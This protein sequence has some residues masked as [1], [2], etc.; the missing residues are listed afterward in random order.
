MNTITL[1]TSAV[2]CGVLLSLGLAATP[3]S[4]SAAAAATPVVQQLTSRHIV[5]AHSG[6]DVAAVVRAAGGR[7][8]AELKIINAVGADLTPAQ[9]ARLR[10]TPG[11]SLFADEQ[12]E[13]SA[14]QRKTASAVAAPSDFTRSSA[15]NGTLEQDE[16]QRMLFDRT[17]Y[18]HPLI[19]NAP[20]LHRAG[21]TGSGVTVAVVDTGL[22]WEADTILSK[23]AKFRFDTTDKPLDDDPNGH[24]T[25]VSS[26]IASNGLATNWISEG[27]APGAGI[28]ALRAF[29]ADGS[30]SYIDVI[31][32]LDYAV[33]NRVKYNIRVLNLSFSAT[34]RSYYWD[35]PLNQ[36]VMK[37]WQA[38]IVVV[39]AAGNSGP[40]AMSIGVPGN[41]PYVITV[42]AMTDN[43][44]PVDATDDKLATFSSTGPTYE[45][46]VKPEVVAPG[47]HIPSSMPFDGYIASLYPGSM[48]G[49]QRQFKMSGTSQATAIVSGIVALMLQKDPSLTPDQVKCKLLASARPAVNA[50]G[51]AAYTVFQ[52]GAGL[53]NALAA[54]GS[55]ASDCANRGLD[56]A[57]D[58]AGSAHYQGPANM[59]S[60]GSYYL[61][62]ENGK[63]ISETGLTWNGAYGASGGYLF[64]EGK[65]WSRTDIWSTGRLW[66]RSQTWSDSV[67][68]T[69][70]KLFSRGLTETMSINRWVEHE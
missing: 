10:Q 19:V 50:K 68:W 28:G 47:G 5:Q 65:L 13:V 3:S 14:R 52:Q 64:S 58:L 29:G 46:F 45:G 70:G 9:I 11:I 2:V 69:Q 56:I 57:R 21:T 7:I 60:G 62:D 15:A 49:S 25:H 22:W 53:V 35:D 27:I 6:Q 59:D 8:V 39:A 34:P 54:V 17:E 4:P 38:G 26:I 23:T 43:Y 16:L 67:P 37:A 32:A 30:G 36:A 31:E 18:Y 66:S 42:G 41:V 12:L 48:I 51:K 40:K 1:R 44:T 63:R 55:G 20:D 61:A 24:G 33:Q